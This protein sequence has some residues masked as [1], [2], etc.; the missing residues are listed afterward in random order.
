MKEKNMKRS[1]LVCVLAL[2]VAAFAGAAPNWLF[3]PGSLA[4]SRRVQALRADPDRD[5]LDAWAES[6]AGTCPTNAD[7]AGDGYSDYYSRTNASA[8]TWGELYDDGDGMPNDWERAVGLDPDRFDAHDDPDADGWTNWEEYMAGTDPMDAASAPAPRMAFALDY[9]GTQSLDR[10]IVQSYSARVAGSGFGGRPDGEYSVSSSGVVSLVRGG[11]RGGWNRFFAF[12][13]LNGNGAFD[14]GEPA[15]ISTRRLSLASYDTAQATIPLT[16]GLFGFPRFSWPTN[17]ASE[18]GYY[19]VVFRRDIYGAHDEKVGVFQVPKPRNYFHEGD[20]IAAGTNGL[21]FGGYNSQVFNWYVFDG[22]VTTGSSA[23]QIWPIGGSSD[24]DV[25]NR[26]SYNYEGASSDDNTGSYFVNADTG[27]RTM[28]AIYPKDGETVHGPLVDF[29]WTMDHRNEGV[30]ITVKNLD[31]GT[32][33][34]G[35]LVIP[36]PRRHGVAADGRMPVEYAGYYSACPQ[37]EGNSSL[38]PLPSGRYSYTITERI[39]GAGPSFTPQSVSGMFVLENDDAGQGRSEV[40]GS[41]YYF[42]RSQNGSSFPASVKIQAFALP[43]GAASGA[44]PSGNPVAQATVLAPGEFTLHGLADGTYA[45]FAFL[46]QNNNT[47]ADDWESQGYGV[48][49][50]TASPVFYATPQPLVVNGGDLEGVSIVLHSR[51]TD[52]DGL[53]DDWEWKKS[54]DLTTKNGSA[55]DLAAFAADPVPV[56]QP[57]VY[58]E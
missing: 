54:G 39:D 8:L 26:I 42:G 43:E 48:L 46:D 57:F 14:T 38:N 16:D 24:Y 20:L 19:T 15:G 45:V 1:A 49:A 53:D 33:H 56:G 55:A 58:G 35:S 12:S 7:T 40:K 9:G 34:I 28:Q 41:V 17:R 18:N 29:R 10:V 50:G 21:P 4:A 2:C 32:T 31:T 30:T 25:V 27:R 23:K 6:R 37:L 22:T 3:S 13:D 11:V 52:N 51:D 47:C 36:I 5:G 44:A